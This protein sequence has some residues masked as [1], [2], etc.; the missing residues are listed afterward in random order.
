MFRSEDEL[1]LRR[2]KAREIRE[3]FERAQVSVEEQH[4]PGMPQSCVIAYINYLVRSQRRA[5]VTI[6][7]NGD[8]EVF[9]SK[10]YEVP[11]GK[12]GGDVNPGQLL[13]V[14]SLA[15]GTPDL[16]STLVRQ[17]RQHS[18]EDTE[19]IPTKLFPPEEPP[20]PFAQLT[21]L[22]DLIDAHET[23]YFSKPYNEL[24]GSVLARTG[25]VEH[26]AAVWEFDGRHVCHSEMAPGSPKLRGPDGEIIV[27]TNAANIRLEPFLP[28][29]EGQ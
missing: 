8:C 29:N 28:Q 21:T 26:R 20:V 6:A 14:F 23:Y 2:E 24:L 19:S 4:Y 27:Y 10:I 12:T 13:R 7:D 1:A 15:A 3:A 11:P 25:R 5:L 22:A 17:V 9:L 16:G 18:I